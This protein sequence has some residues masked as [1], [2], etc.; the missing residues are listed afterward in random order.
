MKVLFICQL[1]SVRSP[2]GE[3]L[4]RRR[5]GV[6]VDAQSCGLNPV[7]PNDFM[8]TVMREIGIDMSEH[9]P[10]SLADLQDEAFDL[11]IAF[12][13]SAYQEAQAAFEGMDIPIE[14][15]AV[16]DPGEGSLDVRAMLNNYRAI[17]TNIDTRLGRRFGPKT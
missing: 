17:R 12:T 14:H 15:W 6:A 5:M 3:G 8:I 2:M 13:T 7:E 1:N 10:T 11:V 9:V 4:L 16:A